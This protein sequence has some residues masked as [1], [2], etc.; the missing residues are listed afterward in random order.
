[1][2]RRLYMNSDG[3][4]IS[5]PGYDAVTDTNPC[6]FAFDTRNDAYW[7]PMLQG[8]LSYNQLVNAYFSGYVDIMYG[9]WY[10]NAPPALV[11]VSSNFYSGLIMQF[12]SP[13]M[14]GLGGASGNGAIAFTSMNDRIRIYVE[15][16]PWLMV[17]DTIVP[18]ANGL[19]YAVSQPKY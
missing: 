3:L 7:S 10:S 4:R 8:S 2:T 17:S 19:Y 5:L 9:G 11:G 1:M 12:W 14:I 15:A 16:E 13:D 6:H 18:I